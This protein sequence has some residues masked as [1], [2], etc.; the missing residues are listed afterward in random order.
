MPINRPINESA[1]GRYVEL[2]QRT[3][4]PAW[5]RQPR[6]ICSEAVNQPCGHGSDGLA[7]ARERVIDVHEI[8][9]V[10]CKTARM[11]GIARWICE[12]SPEPNKT[13]IVKM[14]LIWVAIHEV[15]Q[16]NE[17]HTVSRLLSW[18]RKCK[19][20]ARGY[21]AILYAA[22]C[23][24]GILSHAK[25]ANNKSKAPTEADPRLY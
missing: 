22:L 1:V 6:A 7:S 24:S 14:G 21:H 25:L 4:L 8:Q 23:H 5:G 12:E 13:K 3:R 11:R 9:T 16:L 18:K 20:V 10:S 15:M 19:T 17:G 2:E